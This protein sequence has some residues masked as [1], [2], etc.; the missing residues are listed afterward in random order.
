M[1]I[2][3]SGLIRL[4]FL[5]NVNVMKVTFAIVLFKKEDTY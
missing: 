1:L 2:L 3:R 4:I 5:F